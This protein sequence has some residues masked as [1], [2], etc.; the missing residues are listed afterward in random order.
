MTKAREKVSTALESLEFLKQFGIC[1]TVFKSNQSFLN[2]IG[3]QF[4]VTT[5]PF[6]R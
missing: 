5:K 2:K 1:S 4:F 3:Q 6:I